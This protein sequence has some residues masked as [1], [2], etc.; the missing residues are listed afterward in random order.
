MR[1]TV[2]ALAAS[3]A[4]FTY[5]AMGVAAFAQ[6]TGSPSAAVSPPTTGRHAPT[7]ES[8]AERADRLRAI[9]QLKPAQEPA[10]QAYVGALDTA[11][12]GMMDRDAGPRLA[13]TPERLARME[14]NMAQ[15]Q[16]AGAAMIQATRTFYDQL[17]A[18]QKR[19]FDALPMMGMHGDMGGK[20]RPGDRRGDHRMRMD[21]PP[22]A[23][24]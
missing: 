17:D 2:Q 3:A 7:M 23:A 12:R 20:M 1:Q 5:A 15:H 13:T 18:S 10:L 6:P 8:Q 9:L 4:F 11:R 14:Q 19:A 21:G 22:P 24:R 16:T